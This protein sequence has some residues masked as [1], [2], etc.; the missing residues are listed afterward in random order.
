MKKSNLYTRTGDQGMT[1]L[2][3]GRR[4]AKA[5]TRLEAYGTVDELNS[6]I[7]LLIALWR[8]P[9]PADDAT[10]DLL[11]SVQN[12]LFNIGS[13][14]A[15]D[16]TANPG[17]RCH[18]LTAESVTHLETAIDRA[19]AEV[20]PMKCFV[21]PGGTVTASQ[22]HVSRTVCRRCERRILALADSVE[23][24]PAVIE[25]INRLSDLLFALARLANHRAS[26]PDTPW[27]QP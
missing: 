3:G 14:L 22:A 5:S 18:G 13:Y 11:T 16:N 4:V 27:Q 15:T 25:Y 24:D 10:I 6:S 20:P 7:G 12:M 23:I 1:S 21:L 26:T 17:A 9:M 19:D 8:R 2:V